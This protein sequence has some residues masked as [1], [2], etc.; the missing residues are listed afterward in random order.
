MGWEL[1]YF[2][3]GESGSHALEILATVLGIS[4]LS[5]NDGEQR[6][7]VYLQ[8]NKPDVGFKFR[9]ALKNDKGKL[10][11]KIR[12]DKDGL[13]AENWKKGHIGKTKLT[14][15][16]LNN[17][18]KS[19]P[20]AHMNALPDEFDVTK[21]SIHCIKSRRNI[22]L[23]SCNYDASQI[24]EMPSGSSSVVIELAKLTLHRHSGEKLGNHYSICLEGG[25]APVLQAIGKK[26]SPFFRIGADMPLCMGYPEFIIKCDTVV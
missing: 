2:I 17:A 23:S 1:R 14:V 16:Q 22:L 19:V 4:K 25:S 6:T 18:V 11:Y 20:D 3:S 21:H 12:T 26:L 10:E 9:G 24:G 8:L 5:L 13:G 15:P 7:D